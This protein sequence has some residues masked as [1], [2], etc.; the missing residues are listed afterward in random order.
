MHTS[1]FEA[2]EQNFEQAQRQF[3]SENDTQGN[4]S[5][6]TGKHWID[7]DWSLFDDRRGDLP[8]F[9]VDVLST[10]LSDWLCRLL[11]EPGLGLTR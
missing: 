11:A 6:N 4:S 2:F 5:Q 10:E 3:S 7:P 1:A 8:E 9:P